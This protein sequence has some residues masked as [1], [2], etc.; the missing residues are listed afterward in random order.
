[1]QLGETIRKYRKQ[2]KL[3]Q[4]QMASR[5]GVTAPA[6]N[7]WENGNSFPDIM[8]LAPIARLLGISLDTLLS[9]HE[10]L[11]TEEIESIVKEADRQLK[12]KSYE[13]VFSWAQKKLAKY[14]NCDQ[15]IWQIAV[16]FDAHRLV[17]EVE[18]QEIYDEY[19]Y[20]LYIRVLESK[21]EKLRV[22][23]ADSLYGFC[24][25]KKEYNE[26]EKY[27]KYFSEQ[28]PERKRKQAQIY[29]ET[30]RI[31]EAYKAYE[32]ILFADYQILSAVLHGI[33]QLAAREKDMKKARLVIEKQEELARWFEMGKYHEISIRLELAELEKD[34]DQ[35]YS[36]REE[37]L[38]C[39][40]Q[41]F[42]FRKSK[43]YEHMEFKEPKE[44]FS[45][46]LRQKLMED[47]EDAN[48]NRNCD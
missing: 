20:S 7:K 34:Q 43:L 31:Y 47:F 15:L 2:K 3:T 37:L 46:E 41:I 13:Q 12:E 21:N 8:L 5:L 19:L 10:E 22:S 1:M 33:Y 23:A 25:R 29:S 14:P 24:M 30:G 36:I 11:T 38:S 40:D 39:I 35:I 48:E 45:K 44:E 18:D 26:A 32:E 27:L 9:Y 17:K 42:D 4:E 6:V 28:N 16:I